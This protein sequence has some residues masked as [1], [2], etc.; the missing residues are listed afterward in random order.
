MKP[1]IFRTPAEWRAWLEK[2]H[3]KS[4][5][6]WL[7]YYKKASGKKSVTYNEALD[8]A[9]CFG[10]IDSIVKRLDEE[11][12]M[13]RYSPRKPGSIWSARNKAHIARLVAEGRLAPAGKAKVEA[14]KKDGSWNK[15]DT[16]D[17]RPETPP[18]L[19]AALKRRPD[20]KALWDKQ[21][22]SHKK[23]YSW[24]V[25]DAK[26]PETRSRRVAETLRRIQAGRKPGM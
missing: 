1:K 19:E 23:M 24:W 9:L 17:V 8:E 21:P 2:N 5:E 6:V 15:L 11:K 12:Y 3:A 18:D 22:P 16:I 7:A 20:I 4:A 25:I 26:R 14:A 13:Q 10:W